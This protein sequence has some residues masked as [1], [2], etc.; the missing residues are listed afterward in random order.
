MND[1]AVVEIVRT[2][3]A[4]RE[5][6]FRAWTDPNELRRWSTPGDGRP[7]RRPTALSRWSRSSSAIA[8]SR[9]S[10]C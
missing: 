10:W 2:I 9:P 3:E 4:P 6:V 8:A 7:D 5:Q 1:D